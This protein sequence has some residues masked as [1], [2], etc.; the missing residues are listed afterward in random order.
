MT[1]GSFVSA[2]PQ[3]VFGSPVGGHGAGVVHQVLRREVNERIRSLEDGARI[4][5]PEVVDVCCECVRRDCTGRVVMTVLEY[6]AIR[7]FPSRFLI[8]EGH[9]VAGEERVVA[10]AR[11]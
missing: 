3:E 10:E 7:R 6:E 1:E 2:Q 5:E 11:G 9:E 4:A 8:R